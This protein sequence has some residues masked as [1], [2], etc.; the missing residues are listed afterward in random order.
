MS[1]SESF[2]TK[3]VQTYQHPEPIYVT[4]P[5]MP[6]LSK[7]TESLEKIWDTKW[8]TNDGQFH[9]EFEQ[10]LKGYL[11]VEHLNLFTN[12]TIAL[13]VALQ[14][15]RI[16]S[17][18][19]ITTPFTFAATPHVL[20]WN[21]VQPVF[22]DIEATN[23]N[24]DPN[25]IEE[26]INPNT[27]AILPVHVFGMPCDVE[28]IQSIADRH[29]LF[30]IY[31]A[32]HAFGVRYQGRSIMEYGDIS[33][34]SFHATKLFTTIEGGSLVSKSNVQRERIQFLRNFGIADEETVIGPGINGKMS[35]FQ[36]AFGLL[37]M[38]T[39]DEEIAARRNLTRI[40]REQLSKVEGI[41][42]TKDLAEL[43]YNYA[44]FPILVDRDGFGV[45][46]N[47]LAEVLMKCNFIP[48][49]YFYPLCS[50]YS[51]YAALPSSQPENLPVAQRVANE[52]LCLPLYG[53]LEQELVR[54]VCSIIKEI[55]EAATRD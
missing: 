49:K 43:D 1:I 25:R 31:D 23:Y 44:Y 54:K 51:C 10:R 22:C 52:V 39:I 35:E 47:E 40:Y 7:Y 17:G 48:R 13:L 50:R 45:S 16:N 37:G 29:G 38:E 36:A 32:A 15:L 14:A 21:G 19:V 5:R 26:L 41:K 46:R 42:I 9:Q 11:G 8:L 4:Q 27:K 6:S 33:A 18:E 20:H 3:L 53:S 24:L 12:G 30:V 2:L 55:H 28:A 34:I